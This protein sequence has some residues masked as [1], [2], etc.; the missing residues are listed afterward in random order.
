M[1]QNEDENM[2]PTSTV[3]LAVSESG[4]VADSRLWMV[5]TVSACNPKC[6]L[7]PESCDIR[8]VNI[9]NMCFGMSFNSLIISNVEPVELPRIG[10]NKLCYRDNACLLIHE[11]YC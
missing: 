11:C 10:K 1:D 6:A 8:F 3:H 5:M 9:I 7:D 4:N 2:S